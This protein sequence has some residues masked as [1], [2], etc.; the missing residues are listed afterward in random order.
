[1]WLK[2]GLCARMMDGVLKLETDIDVFGG[3]GRGRG[4]AH[5]GNESL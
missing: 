1:M 4:E 5:I 2:G 3:I